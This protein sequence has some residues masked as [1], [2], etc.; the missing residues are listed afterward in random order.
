MLDSFF[1]LGPKANCVR[2]G[3]V[4]R[5]KKQIFFW[6]ATKSIET[7]DT[8]D[9]VQGSMSCTTFFL[10]RPKN[11]YWR[12]KGGLSCS[13]CDLKPH[14]FSSWWFQCHLKKYARQKGIFPKD[15][16]ENRKIFEVLPPSFYLKGT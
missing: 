9:P 2:D 16:G 1:S 12:K 15:R 3:K 6:G 13:G 5:E 7:L 10:R 11:T 14:R 8:T 4:R